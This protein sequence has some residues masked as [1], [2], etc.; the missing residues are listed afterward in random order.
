MKSAVPAL[1]ASISDYRLCEE[2]YFEKIEVAKVKYDH[3]TH[4]ASQTNLFFLPPFELYV[5]LIVSLSS[6]T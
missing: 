2:Y 4:I 5:I 1:F 6:T 3:K